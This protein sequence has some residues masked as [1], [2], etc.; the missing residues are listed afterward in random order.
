MSRNQMIRRRFAESV[1]WGAVVCAGR[2]V[3]GGVLDPVAVE[4]EQVVGR[5]D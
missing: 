4:L 2:V 5:C 3:L 1:R